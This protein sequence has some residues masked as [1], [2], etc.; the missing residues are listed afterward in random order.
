MKKIV[1]IGGGGHCISVL[2]SILSCGEYEEI[3]IVDSNVR[4]NSMILDCAVVGDD[5][6]LPELKKSGFEYAFITV[7]SIKTAKKR[8]KLYELALSLGYEVPIICDPSA[9]VSVNSNIGA[10]TF[11]G[12]NSVINAKAYVGDNCIINSGAIIE[13]EC[14]IGEFSH[15]SVGAILCGMC[16][17]GRDSFIGAGSTIIQG[18]TIGNNVVIGAGSVV[19]SDVHDNANVYGLVKK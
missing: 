10:G 9:T 14:T 19:I 8:R 3:V 1:L 15:I 18:L 11:I 17:I 16:S 4:I 5:S 13:H 6:I 7:G 2:D 12:K